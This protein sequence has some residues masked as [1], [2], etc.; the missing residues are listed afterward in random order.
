[1]SFDAEPGRIGQTQDVNTEDAYGNGPVLRSITSLRGRVRPG[2]SGGPMVDAAGQVVATVFA[3]I[4]SPPAGGGGGFAVPNALVRAQQTGPA[5]KRPALPDALA[6]P[7]AAGPLKDP[8]R[9]MVCTPPAP[10]SMPPGRP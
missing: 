9:A 2:N 6:R 10:R 5:R 3:A 1:R 7:P 8:G 4:V